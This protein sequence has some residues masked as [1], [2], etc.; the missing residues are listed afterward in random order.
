MASNTANII[1]LESFVEGTAPLAC[2]LNRMLSTIRDLDTRSAEL[3]LKIKDMVNE[4]LSKPSQSLSRS[5]NNVDACQE[6]DALRKQIAADQ[7][8]MLQ[9]CE[10]K[11]SLASIAK[12]M[13]DEYVVKVE[14]YKNDLAQELN[15]DPAALDVDAFLDDALV[16]NLSEE[17]PLVP[18]MRSRDSVLDI[19]GSVEVKREG[20]RESTS[21]LGA[22]PQQTLASMP[23]W[24]QGSGRSRAPAG[25]L[26]TGGASGAPTVVS[27]AEWRRQQQLNALNIPQ[28]LAP[29]GMGKAESRVLERKLSQQP[30]A[31]LPLDKRRL[32]VQAEVKGANITLSEEQAVPLGAAPGDGVAV[33]EGLVVPPI[34]PGYEP[35]APKPQGPGRLLGYPDIKES[36]QGKYAELYWPDDKLWYLIQIQSV[37]TITRKAQIAYVTGE[38]EELDLME[39]VK[40]GH[41]SIEI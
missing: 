18:S 31:P 20:R 38:T 4:V 3:K 5:K 33:V 41:M 14:K 27:D 39:I 29:H 35:S 32:L 12:S 13:L 8:M 10:E 22:V 21:N 23:S 17:K 11:Q 7:A 1:Y 34:P 2:E 16:G 36:L 30:G 19:K 9:W 24:E 28:Q 40:E 26:G 15:V 6:V 25:G 37:N